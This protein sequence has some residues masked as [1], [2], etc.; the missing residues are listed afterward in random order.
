MDGL[1]IHWTSC[2]N[3][4][5]LLKSGFILFHVYV[6]FTGRIDNKRSIVCLYW[7]KTHRANVGFVWSVWSLCCLHNVDLVC[8]RRVGLL[9]VCALC[10]DW[11]SRRRRHGP[12]HPPTVFLSPRPI[13]RCRSRS[14][15]WGRWKWW[16]YWTLPSLKHTQRTEHGW[17]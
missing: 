5:P 17:V 8:G 13:G 10:W 9:P 16:G 12:R 15:W 3:Q 14:C 2:L 7:C 4:Y 6:P 1:P 11:P